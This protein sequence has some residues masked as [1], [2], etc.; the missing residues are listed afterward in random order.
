MKNPY[1]AVIITVAV[2]QYWFV[3]NSKDWLTWILLIG[4]D[5]SNSNT[6]HLYLNH[7]SNLIIPPDFSI[8]RLYM[9]EILPIR[10]KTLSNQSINRSLY[11]NQV[12]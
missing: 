12:V 7:S 8:N 4:S 6:I 1:T 9:A 10:R 3:C 2:E 5:V 11:Q